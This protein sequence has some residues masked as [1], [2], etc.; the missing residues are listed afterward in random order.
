MNAIEIERE[1]RD[2]YCEDCKTW[3]DAA[4]VTFSTWVAPELED[5][6]MKRLYT[7]AINWQ[8]KHPDTYIQQEETVEAYN[9][10]LIVSIT[11]RKNEADCSF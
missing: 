8:T 2:I 7:R 11:V 6:A 9:G 1:F 4:E 10:E 3:A 5:K